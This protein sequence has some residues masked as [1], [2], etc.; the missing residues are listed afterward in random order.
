MS[1]MTEMLA[2]RRVRI[3]KSALF[4]RRCVCEDRRDGLPMFERMSVHSYR[5][6]LRWLREVRIEMREAK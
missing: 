1:E 2:Q 5:R 3:I 4:W 6:R